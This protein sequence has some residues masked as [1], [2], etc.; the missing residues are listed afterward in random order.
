MRVLL[1]PQGRELT[2]ARFAL[3]HGEHLQGVL[4]EVGLGAGLGEGAE[5]S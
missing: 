1:C 2:K 4:Q 5:Q 3:Q